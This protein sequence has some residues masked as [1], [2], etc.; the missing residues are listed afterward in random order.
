MKLTQ[1]FYSKSINISITCMQNHENTNAELQLRPLPISFLIHF[2]ELA[3]HDLSFLIYLV[4]QKEMKNYQSANKCKL[5]KSAANT[6]TTVRTMKLII[7]KTS[8]GTMHNLN[9]HN[10]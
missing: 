4:T 8:P 5:L 10:I 7:K 1:S 6:E 9:T 2:S 3:N